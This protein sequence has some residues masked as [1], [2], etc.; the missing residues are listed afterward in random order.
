MSAQSNVIIFP[1]AVSSA[2]EKHSLPRGGPPMKIKHTHP[3]YQDEKERMEKLQELKKACI[4]K[5]A[6]SRGAKKRSA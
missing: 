4:S 6:I 5:V 2:E 1:G 3:E